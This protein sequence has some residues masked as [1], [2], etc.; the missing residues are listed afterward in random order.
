MGLPELLFE[1]EAVDTARREIAGALIRPART[2]S[3]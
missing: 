3:R 1:I 2:L